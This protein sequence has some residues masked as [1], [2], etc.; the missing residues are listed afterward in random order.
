MRLRTVLTAA[1]L[2]CYVLSA[3][4]A[5][6]TPRLSPT[7]PPAVTRHATLPLNLDVER[8]QLRALIR[9]RHR[10]VARL[11][12]EQAQR[13]QILTLAMLT[14]AD[15]AL[16]GDAVTLKTRIDAS[17]LFRRAPPRTLHAPA[18][19][20]SSRLRAPARSGSQAGER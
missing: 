8:A 7:F 15:A 5:L 6:A 13:S 17:A 10:L 14:A 3:S 19:V 11:A 12:A 16:S 4:P 1:L 2:L 9:E 20:G 18:P